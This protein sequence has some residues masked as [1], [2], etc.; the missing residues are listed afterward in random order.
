MIL[1]LIAAFCPGGDHL[2]RTLSENPD[3]R[4]MPSSHVNDPFVIAKNDN[5]TDTR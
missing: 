4:I 2:Y 1:S 5:M 3:C